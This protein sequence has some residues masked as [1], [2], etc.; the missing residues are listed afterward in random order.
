[1]IIHVLLLILQPKCGHVIC[2][3]N[4]K[5]Y[6]HQNGKY[7]TNT[8]CDDGFSDIWKKKKRDYLKC[9]TDD[10][11]P[12]S[13]SSNSDGKFPNS[14]KVF[15]RSCIVKC[16]NEHISKIQDGGIVS[17]TRKQH[18]K[19]IQHYSKTS[20]KSPDSNKFLFNTS[21]RNW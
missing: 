5:T 7:Q 21:P 11:I 4:T 15:E 6:S 18:P 20:T 12:L 3:N 17:K 9:N 13:S 8:D 19:Q 2:K 1:M 10:M 16:K 14:A